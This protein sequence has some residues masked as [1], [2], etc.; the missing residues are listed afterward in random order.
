MRTRPLPTRKSLG[1]DY[2][3]R[4]D[5]EPVEARVLRAGDVVMESLDHPFIITK[6]GTNSR[7]VHVYGKY[8]WQ[9]EREESWSLGRFSSVDMFDRATKGEY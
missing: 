2:N 6:V 3:L 8:I 7:G 1:T 5:T 9:T 4:P